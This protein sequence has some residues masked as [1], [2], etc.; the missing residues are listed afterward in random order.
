MLQDQPG[1]QY[2]GVQDKSEADPRDT[3]IDTLFVGK[4]SRGRCDK[5]FKVTINDYRAKLGHDPSNPYYIA[6]QDALNSGAPYLWIQRITDAPVS[7]ITC[8]GAEL[9]V[10]IANSYADGESQVNGTDAYFAVEING[11]W[12]NQDYSKQ[13][14]EVLESTGL[15]L[16]GYMS[17]N[18]DIIISA[19][20]TGEYRMRLRPSTAQQQYSKVFNSNDSYYFNPTIFKDGND[21]CFCLSGNA[22]YG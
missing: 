8:A 2:S 5:P 22:T 18:G 4:F 1:I 7:Q 9:A 3:L 21:F 15:P 12:Y 16:T 13:I 19:I 6:V 11:V 20:N 17:S 10:A 14:S